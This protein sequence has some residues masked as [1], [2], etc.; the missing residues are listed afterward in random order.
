MSSATS[1][2][3]L[4]RKITIISGNDDLSILLLDDDIKNG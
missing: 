4:K 1:N 2:E 3:N